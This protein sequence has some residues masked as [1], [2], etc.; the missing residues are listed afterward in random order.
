MDR[1]QRISSTRWILGPLL[2]ASARVST[3]FLANLIYLSHTE[4]PSYSRCPTRS[5]RLYRSPSKPR[6][7]IAAAAMKLGAGAEL[8]SAGQSSQPASAL[9]LRLITGWI[10][11]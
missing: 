8:T 2:E 9:A 6:R 5:R 11:Q 1:G 4:T 10:V 7:L 3:R